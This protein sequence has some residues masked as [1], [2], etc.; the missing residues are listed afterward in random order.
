MHHVVRRAA[1]VR[2]VRMSRI[3][4]IACTICAMSMPAAP[5]YAK[6]AAAPIAINSC[7]PMLQNGSTQSVLGI[8]LAQ[9]SS[10]IKIQFTNES[11]KTANLVNFGVTSN[12]TSF[13]IRDVGTFSPNIEITHRYTNGAGQSFVLPAIIAPQVTCVVDSVRFTDGT[14]WRPGDAMAAQTPEPVAAPGNLLRATPSRADVPLRGGLQ[15]FMVSTGEKLAGFS[16]GDACQGIA[17]ISLIAAGES[18]ATYSVKPIA[19]G[20]CTA[21]IR[22]QDG[23]TLAV[24]IN[25]R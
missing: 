21:T 8:P 2:L 7:T 17:T 23:H 18:S 3:A 25:V 1:M 24:P 11:S 9:S 10:G 12:G 13:V 6:N 14:V 19:S 15:Y 4:G 20:S 22:D 16:E 5:E